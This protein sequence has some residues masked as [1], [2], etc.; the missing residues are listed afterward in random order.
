MSSPCLVEFAHS[1][2]GVFFVQV[3]TDFCC[4]NHWSVK[5][6]DWKHHNWCPVNWHW[7]HQSSCWHHLTTVVF[8][9]TQPS[10]IFNSFISDTT[11]ERVDKV[12]RTDI[13]HPLSYGSDL[14]HG[15]FLKQRT[16]KIHKQVATSQIVFKH[17]GFLSPVRL[18]L[19]LRALLGIP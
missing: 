16:N 14:F 5:W 17:S 3:I 10:F 2:H 4:L 6:S 7:K 15:S 12:H 8:R 19:Q 9:L 11:Y 13:T 18:F 1:V